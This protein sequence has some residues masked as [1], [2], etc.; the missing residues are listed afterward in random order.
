ME[1]AKTRQPCTVTNDK[2]QCYIGALVKNSLF[3]SIHFL[4]EVASGSTT[5]PDL[6][7][8]RCSNDH[9]GPWRVLK[10]RHSCASKDRLRTTQALRN[11]YLTYRYS[12]IVSAIVSAIV[13]ISLFTSHHFNISQHEIF[14][15]MQ[16]S[17]QHNG[18]ENIP[19]H[20]SLHSSEQV[21]GLHEGA[22]Q[23]QN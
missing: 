21:L 20:R 11:A 19:S 23:A 14:Q 1:P 6:T 22:S 12:C 5:Q 15:L 16:S 7:T 13:M 8:F 3:V 4:Y 18:S 9:R 2:S 10:D 17:R